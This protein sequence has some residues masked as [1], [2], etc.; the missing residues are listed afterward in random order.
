M[1]HDA[2]PPT[3]RTTPAQAAPPQPIAPPA[4]ALEHTMVP[5]WMRYT[6]KTPFSQPTRDHHG[7]HQG[8]TAE[9][10]PTV[11]P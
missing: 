3:T 11:R 9:D 4:A 8:D 6:P 10:P 2:P 5:P 7:T 1:T